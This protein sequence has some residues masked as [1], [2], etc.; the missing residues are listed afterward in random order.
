MR[1]VYAIAACVVVFAGSVARAQSGKEML[2]SCQLFQRGVH[3]EKGAIFLP[4]GV[5]AAQCWDFMEAVQQFTSLADRDGKPLLNA[6]AK[7]DTTTTE[8]VRVFVAYALGH[9]DKLHLPAAAVA[10]NA[11]ADA[12]PC[13]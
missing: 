12:F 9:P 3:E 8:I 2:Q 7:P 10:Y 13:K 6:C 11:M 5:D 1:W 4:P